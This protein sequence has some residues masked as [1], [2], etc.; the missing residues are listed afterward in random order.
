MA[1]GSR[2]NFIDVYG[3][4]SK[5]FI[6]KI[7]LKKTDSPLKECVILPGLC[8]DNKILIVLHA[9][10]ILDVYNIESGQFLSNLNS[11]NI[12]HNQS[13]IINEQKI[14]QIYSSSNSRYFCGITQCGYIQVYDL[15]CSFV[16]NLKAT[17][18]LMKSSINSTQSRSIEKQ[19]EKKSFS[20]NKPKPQNVSKRVQNLLENSQIQSKLVKILKCYNEYPSRYR[21]FIWKVLLKLPENYESYASFVERGVHPSYANFSNKYPI[22]SQK[23]VRLMEKTLSALAYWSPIFADCEFLPLLIFPFV[24]LYLNNQVVCFEICATFISKIPENKK[25]KANFFLIN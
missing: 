5:E 15:D 16:K 7:N 8:Y 22:K 23:C 3:I 19:E 21:M 12:V 25:R 13:Q 10:G 14:V 6:R 11:Y 1:V 18:S 9:D 17:S 20:F 24:K 2:Q 4:E